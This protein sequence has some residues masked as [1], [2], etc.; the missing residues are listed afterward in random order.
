M[1]D[2]V[3]SGGQDAARPWRVIIAAA[4]VGVAAVTLGLSQFMAGLYLGPHDDTLRDI[5]AG[6]P[7]SAAIL[8]RTQD[9]REAALSWVRQGSVL[10]DLSVLRFAALAQAPAFSAERRTIAADAVAL[11]RRALALAPADGFGWVRLLQGLAV[12]A[13]PVGEV[14][15][16]LRMAV[17]RAANESTLVRARVNVALLYWR[18]LDG[19]LRA[20]I[21][22]DIRRA[23][24]WSPDA[25]ARLARA[26]FLEDEVGRML[27]GDPRA[28]ARYN[29]ARAWLAAREKR[30]R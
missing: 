17:A 28:L 30:K 16:I 24:L 1:V 29:A 9:G 27:L 26:R 11:Q 21:G 22:A 6:R 19:D 7:V 18:G 10:S 2:N 25:L 5:A 14:T 12:A 4:A 8:K 15:P 20:G 23:A 13:A 3:G